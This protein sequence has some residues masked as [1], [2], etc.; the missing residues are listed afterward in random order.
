MGHAFSTDSD[1]KRNLSIQFIPPI[2]YTQVE[3]EAGNKLV[4]VLNDPDLSD[5]DKKSQAWEILNNRAS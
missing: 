2:H 3:V 4:E 5:A 1:D